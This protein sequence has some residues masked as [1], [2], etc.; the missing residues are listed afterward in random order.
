MRNNFDFFLNQTNILISN[1]CKYVFIKSR[2]HDP[3]IYPLFYL[4]IFLY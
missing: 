3:H 1:C 4:S 2:E